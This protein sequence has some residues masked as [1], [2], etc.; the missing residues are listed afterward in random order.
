MIS[1][2]F[3]SMNLLAPQFLFGLFALA[4]PLIIHLFNFRKTKVVYFSSNQ[5][6]RKI[7]EETSSKRN[8][9]HIIIL[10]CR[11]LFVT[12]LVLA[13][14]Q[15][16]IPPTG[17]ALQ[18][19]VQIYLDNSYSMSNEAEI[20]LSGF[21]KAIGFVDELI[22]QYPLS[23]RFRLLTNDFEPFS[24]R[25]R[26]A[27]EIKEALTE[28]EYSEYGR[29]TDELYFNLN[30]EFSNREAS[31]TY[32]ISDFQKTFNKPLQ[33][34]DS[35]QL[36]VIPINF[37]STQNVYIDTIFIESPFSANGQITNL[38]I[39]FRNS[40]LAEVNNLLTRVFLDGNQ[41][42][43]RSISIP[44]GGDVAIDF[45]ISTPITQ[46]SEGR[47]VFEDYPVVFDNTFYFVL[48]GRPRVKIIELGNE[49]EKSYIYKVYGNKDLFYYEFQSINNPD[50]S[51]LREADL[52]VVN[53]SELINEAL[54]IQ[55][56]NFISKGGS[57]VLIP[58]SSQ[59]ISVYNSLIPELPILPADSADRQVL[60][61][62]D[63]ENPFY[64]GIFEETNQNIMMPEAKPLIRWNAGRVNLLRFRNTQ[65]FLSRVGLNGNIFVFSTS[66]TPEYT[67]FVQHALFVPIMYKIA[68]QSIRN[69]EPLF[70][71]MDSRVVEIAVDSISE[72]EL[73]T[74]RNSQIEVIPEQRK[75]GNRIIIDVDN[76]QVVPGVY[77]VSTEFGE[78]SK[79]AI[80]FDKKE[81][82]LETVEIEELNQNFEGAEIDVLD[83]INFGELGKE[84]SENYKAKPLWK[85][86]LVLALIFLLAEVLVYR[87]MKS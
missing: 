38:S 75:A 41:V 64:S 67:N 53:Q 42:T 22:S 34:E 80:N 77:S 15:P 47:I 18:N 87:L 43:S 54:T 1:F 59:E 37:T 40:G 25:F 72:T 35:T 3:V 13:F 36:R 58:G 32:W 62:P 23:T 82:K 86:M 56:Q 55:L 31:D 33:V 9:K 57:L 19:K 66:L 60:A 7:S 8:L 17:K 74:L 65:P 4:I 44:A 51:Q 11:I 28:I 14:T 29:F 6:L 50:Y 63:F 52:I 68:F 85:Y 73:V 76:G 61:L 16:V 2:I 24:N 12:F 21:E 69:D 10:I 46:A 81:S 5:F 26:S 78:V 27:E 30:D 70:Y 49:L 20:E 83:K 84:L 79:I 39:K 71:R 45:D 48:K